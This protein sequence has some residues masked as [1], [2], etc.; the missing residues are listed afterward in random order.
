MYINF[1]QNRVS[2]SVKAVH[3]IY[4]QKI[5]NCINLQIAIRIFKK[6]RLSDMHYILT[7]IQAVFEINRPVRYLITAKRNYFHRRKDGPTARRTDGRTSRKTTIG[8]FFE[9]EK[10]T[11][12]NIFKSIDFIYIIYLVYLH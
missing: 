9:K 4:L 3:T 10:N 2:R 6:S 12:N 1:Q 7:D 5:A 11:K 8:S